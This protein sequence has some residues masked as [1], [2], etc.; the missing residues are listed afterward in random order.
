MPSLWL[1]IK[2][3]LNRNNSA[4]KYLPKNNYINFVSDD[5]GESLT[6]MCTFYNN[7]E[8]AEF[9][10]FR[11][12]A[13]L[14]FFEFLDKE[15]GFYYERW[16]DAPVHTYWIL[17]MLNKDQIHLFNDLPYSHQHGSNFKLSQT[18][19]C[20]M[21]LNGCNLEWSKKMRN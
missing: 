20:S 12:Q 19:E 21:E 1:T 13:Y 3:W 16:G 15:G 18:N 4:V 9:N 17:F 8:I 6:S 14:D 7:F 5:K 11:N 2:E 10:L